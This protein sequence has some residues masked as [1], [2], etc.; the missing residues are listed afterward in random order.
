MERKCCVCGRA[1]VA[2]QPLQLLVKSSKGAQSAFCIGKIEDGSVT[3]EGFGKE[4]VGDTDLSLPT[5]FGN[6]D[7]GRETDLSRPKGCG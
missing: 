3:T 1:D 5:G 7:Y 4:M 2:G 6:E